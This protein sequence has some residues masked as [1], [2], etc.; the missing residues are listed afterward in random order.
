MAKGGEGASDDA[1]RAATG[2]GWDEWEAFLDARGAREMAHRDIAAMLV[3]EGHVDGGWWAQ[4]VTVGYEKRTG[5]RVTGQTKD[6]GFQVGVRRTMAVAP[7]EAW[8]LL[9]SAEG[10]RHWLGDGAAPAWEMGARYT[11]AD[12]A[13][14]AVRV[15]R[16]GSHLRVTRQPGGWPRASTIQARVEASGD[17]SVVSFHEEH[18]PDADAR[19]ARR[20]HFAAALDALERLAG[21]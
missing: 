9:T 12:G 17:R 19:A 15:F 18:L 21:G 5:R 11:A 6:T 13:E 8:R 20:A 4:M 2:R 10:V 1:V 7:E 3:A 14:G 16:P